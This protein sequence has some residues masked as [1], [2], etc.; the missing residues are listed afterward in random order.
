M[1][2]IGCVKTVFFAVMLLTVFFVFSGVAFSD[3]LPDLFTTKTV[4]KNAP[5][6][7][8]PDT[9][10]V[11]VAWP[12]LKPADN[13][14]LRM[15]AQLPGKSIML[16]KE[17]TVERHPGNYTWFGKVEGDDLS[18]VV[19]TVID[20]VM[21]GT[22][23]T[24]DD[25]YSVVPKGGSY[26]VVRQ[27]PSRAMRV[28]DDVLLPQ[29]ESVP[30]V[31]GAGQSE[32]AGVSLQ[33]DGSRIDLLVLYTSQMQSKYGSGLASKIQ[34]FVDLANAGY[35]NSGI[36]LTLN[37]VGTSS[38]TDSGDMEGIDTTSALKYLS[39]T[40]GSCNSSNP[41]APPTTVL[42]LR[43]AYQADLVSLLRVYDGYSSYCGLGWTLNSSSANTCN[44][45]FGYSV[46]EV[47]GASEAGSGE[48]YCPDATL[49]HE[50]GHNLG[51][52]HDRA[53][54][55]Q[56]LFDYSCGY[57]TP[58]VKYGTIMSYNSTIISYYST[59]LVLYNGYSIGISEGYSNSA[60]NAKTINNSK[61]IVANY[62]VVSNQC[63][64]TLSSA[65]LTVGS[66]SSAGSVNLTASA[67]SCTWNATSNASWITITSG[68]GTGSGTVSYS[69]TANTSASSRTG[70][71]TI[72]GQ[73]Y[74]VTQSGVQ[75]YALTISDSGSGSGTVISSPS[76]ISCG[77]ACS[78]NF[79]SGTTVTLTA[80][81]S[82]GSAFSGWSGGGCSGT[83]SCAF[84]LNGNTTVTATF[85]VVG[86]GSNITVGS[87]GIYATIQSGYNAAVA[88]NTI[89]VQTAAYGENLSFNRNVSVALKGGYDSSFS[90]K[91][92]N[93]VIN[94][95]L[96]ISD[97]AVTLENI[98]IH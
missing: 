44:Q 37:L 2:R 73:T 23:N 49:A 78:A 41:P 84:S 93:S 12:V 7:S 30:G 74:T 10:E 27:D 45:Y 13:A 86:G 3:D 18:T 5:I 25:T 35:V 83:A 28:P 98:I 68:S 17:R 63:A 4:I 22:I 64:Y 89:K 79:N 96:I 48:Y 66:G 54:N 11:D 55:C 80:T 32:R 56:G 57:I 21:F 16:R 47:K 53:H 60:D 20:S 14:P 71:M 24:V 31:L 19:L 9:I 94:G 39:G 91:S 43:D 90:T 81:P 29:V 95:T 72:G 50:T 59:P 38:Y 69:V 36:T 46:V 76:G 77:P 88:G 92:S 1:N 33:E 65:G 52:G 40:S 87:A 70:T 75:Q 26:R 8:D 6:L 67:G 51:G 82:S 15:R 61:Q 62:R 34:H 42:S 97:G 85:N 58:D